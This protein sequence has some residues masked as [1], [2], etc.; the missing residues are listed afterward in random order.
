MVFSLKF[1]VA[2]CIFFTLPLHRYSYAFFLI[3]RFL[4]CEYLRG[5][6][7]Y[8]SVRVTLKR[9]YFELLK[10]CALHSI[11]HFC[12]MCISIMWA[13]LQKHAIFCQGNQRLVSFG[14]FFPNLINHCPKPTSSKMTESLGDKVV[15]FESLR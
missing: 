4:N 13:N 9:P 14:E 5:L 11:T 7:A 15:A 8:I 3:I 2:K 1:L 12:V 10:F 6:I